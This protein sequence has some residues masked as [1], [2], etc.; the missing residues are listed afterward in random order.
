M[1][2]L[3]YKRKMSAKAGRNCYYYYDGEL[4]FVWKFLICT[5]IT[6]ALMIKF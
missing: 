3:F 2:R 1:K 5:V 4:H 6:L